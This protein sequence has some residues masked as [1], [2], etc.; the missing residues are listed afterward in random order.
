MFTVLRKIVSMIKVLPFS[1]H[2]STENDSSL[3]TPIAQLWSC[4]SYSSYGLN[5][6]YLCITVHVL[7]P[8]MGLLNIA[9]STVC[10]TGCKHAQG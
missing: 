5:M 6:L 1:D 8:Q 10:D 7:H 3:K 4:K 2:T 9:V